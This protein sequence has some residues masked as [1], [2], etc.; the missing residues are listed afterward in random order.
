MRKPQPSAYVILTLIF[1][2]FT[3]GFFLGRNMN[4][5]VLTVSVSERVM[6]PP[7]LE[8][9]ATVPAEVIKTVQFPIDINTAGKEE[10]MALPGIGEVL[11]RRIV[12]YRIQNGP[13]RFPEDIRKVEGIGEKTM[14]E[15]RDLITIG[16]YQ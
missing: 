5:G 2:S 10:F 15:I 12:S 13:F 7:T 3:L 16:G 1:V 6:V 11:A 14:K 4:R 8:T 9:E